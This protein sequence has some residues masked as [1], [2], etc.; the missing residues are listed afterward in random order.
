MEPSFFAKLFGKDKK[1]GEEQRKKPKPIIIWEKKEVDF[2]RGELM[3]DCDII[4]DASSYSSD[5]HSVQFIT[6]T[7]IQLLQAA[8]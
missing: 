1:E 4:S 7:P 5:V 2:C 6:L 3:N 8:L